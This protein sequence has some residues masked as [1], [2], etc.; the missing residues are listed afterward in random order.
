MGLLFLTSIDVGGICGSCT[1][2]CWYDILSS[3]GRSLSRTS[4][5]FKL[6][7]FDSKETKQ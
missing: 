5:W 1:G 7:V 3:P 4:N 6:F 2:N